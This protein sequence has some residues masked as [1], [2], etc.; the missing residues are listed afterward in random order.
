MTRQSKCI[1]V[2][3]NTSPLAEMN[4]RKGADLPLQMN[5]VFKTKDKNVVL[6]LK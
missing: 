2:C 4:K 1:C 5:G 3:N 6:E